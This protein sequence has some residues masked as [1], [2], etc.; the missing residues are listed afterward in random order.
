[1][2]THSYKELT[3]FQDGEVRLI[4]A[5]HRETGELVL[6]EEDT[7]AEQRGFTKASLRCPITDCPDPDLTT[8]SRQGR[9]DGYRHLSGG[10]HAPEGI[11]HIQGCEMIARW[12]RGKYPEPTFTVQKEER[13]NAAGERRADVM[14]THAKS[15]EKIAFEIQYASLSPSKWRER[16]DSYAKQGI[17]DVWLFGHFGAHLYVDRHH[18]DQVRLN[19][20]HEAVVASGAPL[21]WINPFTEQLGTAVSNGHGAAG[22]TAHA[23]SDIPTTSGS[24]RMILSPMD[25]FRL[26]ASGL[27]SDLLKDLQANRDTDARRRA[28]W[29]RQEALRREALLREQAARDAAPRVR[30][31]TNPSCR[32][33]NRPLYDG[34][35]KRG[36][37]ALCARGRV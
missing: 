14:V 32:V 7:A 5:R 30:Q 13:S 2:A 33:C 16:H 35:T 23:T 12:L 27:T 15:G 36:V 28:E 1:M 34:F 8:V 29:A 11:F 22:V 31:T 19:P 6:L 9:R 10:G 4:F 26:A 21:L 17:Q 37:H 20:T 24:G 18:A 25:D 3:D